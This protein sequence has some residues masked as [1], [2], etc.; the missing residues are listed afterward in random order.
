MFSSTFFKAI[1]IRLEI[2]TYMVVVPF[3][4]I[5]VIFVNGFNL[6]EAGYFIVG[7]LIASIVTAVVIIPL[8]IFHLRKIVSVLRLETFL[9]KKEDLSEAKT[10]L[11]GF[12][13]TEALYVNCQWGIGV[14]LAGL[15]TS[16]F[17]D[18]DFW[19]YA[20]YVIAYVMVIFTNDVSHFFVCEIEIGKELSHEQWIDIPTPGLRAIKFRSRI[21]FSVF[22]VVWLG[23]FLF[24]Y[25]LFVENQKIR[26]LE[27]IVSFVPVLGLQMTFY[28]GLL[29][30][31]FSYSATK[32]SDDLIQNLL[33]LSKGNVGKRSPMISSDEIGTVKN[34]L[35][36]FNSRLNQI[37]IEINTESGKLFKFS[38]K[39]KIRAQETTGK[40][41]EQASA[42]E[43]MS[44]ATGQMSTSADQIMSKTDEQ[45][46]QMIRTNESLKSL[47][48]KIGE[49]EITSRDAVLQSEKME[50][51]AESGSKKIKISINQMNDIRDITVQIQGISSL[52]GEIAD[53]VG[54]LSL[55]ASIEAARAGESGRGFA[56][57]AQEISKLGESTQ[58][59]SKEIDSLVKQAV[60]AVNLGTGSMEELNFSMTTIL[61]NVED[62][63]RNIRKIQDI[64]K[65]QATINKIVEGNSDSL[66]R[67]TSE[68]VAE[69]KDQ[70]LL[71]KEISGAVE[72]VAENTTFLVSVAEENQAISNLLQEQALQ[73]QSTL[74]FFRN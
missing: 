50:N 4:S 21:F 13:L 41:M 66:F 47:N 1:T 10:K 57:V 42:A 22:S 58:K 72:K 52:V 5:F 60:K 28:V 48:Q 16:N 68:I 33:S 73:L 32:N 31:L 56:V 27:N 30:Y 14:P 63:I 54:L 17:I 25:L 20:S 8:R 37:V 74:S 35:N 53:R 70:A 18:F 44:A 6:K 26:H 45:M 24:G 65:D 62:A 67:F 15:I 55:N 51:V 61:S 40:L 2:I 23:F 71:F 43:E 34:S 11:L 19:N 39:L 7:A 49:I 59:S 29:T 12:P 3:A 69:N 64:S 9:Q 36:D 38:D 46:K